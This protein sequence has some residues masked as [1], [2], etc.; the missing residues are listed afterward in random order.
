MDPT[1]VATGSDRLEWENKS[2]KGGAWYVLDLP[3]GLTHLEVFY[4]DGWRIKVGTQPIQLSHIQSEESAKLEAIDQAMFFLVVS[5][6]E[7][8]KM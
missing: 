5:L 6:H 2:P 7:L 8:R 1:R 3:G 4:E